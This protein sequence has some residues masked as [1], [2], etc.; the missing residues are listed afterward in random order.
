MFAPTI[1]YVGTSHALVA[2]PKQEVLL[3]REGNEVQ[4]TLRTHFRAGPE[5]LAWIVPVPARP[6]NIAKAD[7]DVFVELESHTAPQFRYLEPSSGFH[8]GCAGAQSE[9]VHTG[10]VV[11]ETGSAGIFDYVVLEATDAD[12]LTEWLEANEYVVPAGAES[13]FRRYVERHCWWLAI[14][15]RA[16]HAEQ[17]TLAPHPIRYSYE[18]PEL[19]FPLVISRLS[20]DKLN[21]I[22]I[23]VLGARRYVCENWDN[24]AI[25]DRT[26]PRFN[27]AID[28][29]ALR[30]DEQSPSGT[31]YEELFA[32]LTERRG[33]HVFFTEFASG[34]DDESLRPLLQKLHGKTDLHDSRIV[35]LTRL[36]ALVKPAAM[37]RDVTLVPAE[38][39][40]STNRTHWVSGR[41]SVRYMGGAAVTILALGV[42]CNIYYLFRRSR[43]KS[44]NAAA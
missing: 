2:S 18:S 12:R 28:P 15:L 9:Q 42:L 6:T 14:R 21:E 1:K 7:D 24:A 3:I 32:R 8:I 20:A 36:R 34:L 30:L 29:E 33:G 22:V 13:V 4:V 31:N 37:D 38:G 10:V 40:H 44:R 17:P 11:A 19:V 27:N 41:A 23:Y 16:E 5:E 35:Y 25:E 26:H 43:A 39:G